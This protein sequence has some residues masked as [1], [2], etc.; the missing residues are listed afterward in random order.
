VDRDNAGENSCDVSHH[1]ADHHD[2]FGTA[3]KPQ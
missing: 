1:L 3:K 2:G